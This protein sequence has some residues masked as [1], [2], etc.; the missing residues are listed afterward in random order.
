MADLNR[1]G[2]LILVARSLATGSVS[3]GQCWLSRRPPELKQAGV[4]ADDLDAVIEAW[5]LAVDQI[6]CGRVALAP[7]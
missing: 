7:N 2:F 4:R 6:H 5:S 1:D 3:L